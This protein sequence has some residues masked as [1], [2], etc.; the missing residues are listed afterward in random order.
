MLVTT[1]LWREAVLDDLTWTATMARLARMG[2]F[3]NAGMT[4][5]HAA[6]AAA[7][8]MGSEPLLEA[9]LPEPPLPLS[10]RCNP[11]RRGVV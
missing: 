5:A 1:L 3:V 4:P 10:E 6:D 7:R 11:W 8:E 2:E 9:E